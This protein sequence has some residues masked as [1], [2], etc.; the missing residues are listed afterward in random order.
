MQALPLRLKL[1]PPSRGS[2]ATGSDAHDMSAAGCEPDVE[3]V[4]ALLDGREQHTSVDNHSGA[5]TLVDSK[6]YGG[7]PL[8]GRAT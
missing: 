4:T 8:L 7:A 2:P 6:A 1:A 5:P 3:Q